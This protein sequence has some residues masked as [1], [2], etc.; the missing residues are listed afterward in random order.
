MLRDIFKRSYFITQHMQ[1]DIKSE[2][3]TSGLLYTMLWAIG[4][5]GHDIYHVEHLRLDSLGQ[6]V[7]DTITAREV[8]FEEGVRISFKKDTDTAMCRLSYLDC[9]ISNKNLDKDSILLAHL[10]GLP[11]SNTFLKAASYLPHYGSFSIIRNLILDRSETIIQDDTGVPWRYVDKEDFS[12]QVFGVYAPPVS[13]F[14]VESL[15]QEDLKLAYK[16]PAY[17]GGKMPFSLGYHWN[18]KLQNQMMFVRR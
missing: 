16:D 15:Y 10:Q 9:D 18:S 11:S 5:T 12:C 7:T 2:N 6:V 13:D 4:I 1:E 17:F 3:R 14:T 8:Q